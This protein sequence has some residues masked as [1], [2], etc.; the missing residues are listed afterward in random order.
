MMNIDFGEIF[1]KNG[2][3]QQEFF[4]MLREEDE[5]LYNVKDKW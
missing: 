3:N 4:P 5:K 2:K 1:K